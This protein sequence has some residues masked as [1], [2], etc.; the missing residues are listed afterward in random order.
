MLLSERELRP[1]SC[2]AICHARALVV[3]KLVAY[4]KNCSKSIPVED[5]FNANI[6]FICKCMRI[7]D[8]SFKYIWI[9]CCLKISFYCLTFSANVKFEFS[10]LHSTKQSSE[11]LILEIEMLLE[12]QNKTNIEMMGSTWCILD[13]S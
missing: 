8:Y 2:L 6:F 9:V 4:K 12:F 11:I 1:E 13:S 3:Y 10:L 7:N 5:L